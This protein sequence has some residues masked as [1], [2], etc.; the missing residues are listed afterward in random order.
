M[1]KNTLVK[2]IL[3]I[4]PITFILPKQIIEDASIEKKVFSG[5]IVFKDIEEKS[6][7]GV[8]ATF[9]LQTSSNKLWNILTDYQNFNHNFDNIKKIKVIDEN[10][11]GATI[12][13]W[14]STVLKT[15]HYTVFRKYDEPLHKLTWEELSGDFKT[16][17]GSWEIQETPDLKGCIV[18]YRTF[19]E[20]GGII[21]RTFKNR[22][23]PESIKRINHMVVK[24]KTILE[25][26]NN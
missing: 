1:I 11:K 22:T 20:V 9:L 25:K 21:G 2:I 18:R 10:P 14:I 12:E 3:V 5:E 16:N 7:A 23:K 19:V 13:L 26:Q 8:E 4:M 17:R 24:L 6:T 15:F